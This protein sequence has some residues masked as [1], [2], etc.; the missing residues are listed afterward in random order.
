VT[1]PETA[2][3][4]MMRKF[5]AS[6]RAINGD[7]QGWR[8]PEEPDAPDVKAFSD[9]LGPLLAVPSFGH[10]V[11]VVV[12]VEWL[13]SFDGSLSPYGEDDQVTARLSMYQRSLDWMRESRSG[14]SAAQADAWPERE[15]FCRK[16]SELLATP[17]SRWFVDAILYIED[18]ERE[19]DYADR[20]AWLEEVGHPLA[21]MDWV[22]TPSDEMDARVAQWERE[23]PEWAKKS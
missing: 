11:E 19:M 10:F 4:A 14:L 15:A 9:T 22:W 3:D 23:H 18:F 8:P 21:G 16:L 12:L 17:A 7:Y 20:M 6:L 5:H 13:G 2:E 1:R